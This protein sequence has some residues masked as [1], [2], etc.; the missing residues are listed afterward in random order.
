MP[1][2]DEWMNEWKEIGIL[3]LCDALHSIGMEGDNDNEGDKNIFS[4]R[5]LLFYVLIMYI[6]IRQV[7]K[8]IEIFEVF[9]F[10]LSLHFPNIILRATSCLIYM[11]RYN[12]KH[13]YY[14]ISKKAMVYLKVIIYNGRFLSS[15]C[16]VESG[17]C[18]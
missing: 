16:T 3:L 6:C 17:V 15:H 1:Y 13:V 4:T 9:L 5:C 18:G 12:K 2:L 7:N 11:V 8:F 14:I 10:S